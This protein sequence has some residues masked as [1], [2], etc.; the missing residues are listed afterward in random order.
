FLMLGLFAL[1]WYVLNWTAWGRKRGQTNPALRRFAFAC[2]RPPVQ[3]ER[4]GKPSAEATKSHRQRHG[5]K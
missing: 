1:L 4:S 5:A 3:E 2:N